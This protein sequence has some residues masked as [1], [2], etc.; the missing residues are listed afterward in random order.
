MLFVW[1]VL[2]DALCTRV[3][4]RVFMEHSFWVYAMHVNV[5]AVIT[6]LLTLLLPGH[7]AMAFVNFLLTTVLTLAVIELTCVLLSRFTPK[8]CRVLSGCR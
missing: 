3:R 6:K 5:G 8:V 7:W 2:A 1:W 4:A